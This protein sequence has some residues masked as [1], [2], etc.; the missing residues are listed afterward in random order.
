MPKSCCAHGGLIIYVHNQF[1]SKVMSEVKV[2]SS[3][4]EYLCVKI[5]HRKP[6]SK[7]YVLCNIY[8]KPNEIVNDLDAF[9][10][11]LSSL[12]SKIKSIKHSSYVC[13]DYNIDPLKVKDNK[14]SRIQGF[15]SIYLQQPI[16]FATVLINK[17]YSTCTRQTEITNNHYNNQNY[18][19]VIAQYNLN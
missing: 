12:L 19:C 6:K 14:D 15:K 16:H 4:W 11:E 17:T 13:G 10:K 3:G 8:R 1:Q 2:Q 9:T 18:E 7:I 5:S